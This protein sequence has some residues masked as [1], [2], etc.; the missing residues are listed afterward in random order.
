[1]TPH[2]LFKQDLLTLLG[3]RLT[4][5]YPH[6]DIDHPGIWV[7]SLFQNIRKAI[8][9]GDETAIAIACELIHCDPRLPFG[10]LIKSDLARALKKRSEKLGSEERAQI[11]E[12]TIRLLTMSYAPRELEDYVKLIRKLPREEY[13]S[14]TVSIQPQNEKAERLLSY[15]HQS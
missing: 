9:L 5:Y 14:R 10:K 11:M 4:S 15:L 12:V 8:C 13:I 7:S 3:V 2:I 6:P 1:M